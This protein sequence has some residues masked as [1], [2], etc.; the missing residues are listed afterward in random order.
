METIQSAWLHFQSSQIHSSDM[1]WLRHSILCSGDVCLEVARCFSLITIYHITNSSK[2]EEL[3]RTWETGHSLLMAASHCHKRGGRI[4]ALG[5]SGVQVLKHAD[6]FQHESQRSWLSFEVRCFN[7]LHPCY[8]TTRSKSKASW[9][10]RLPN[11]SLMAMLLTM[12][13]TGQPP[14]AQ[15]AK[16]HV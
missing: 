11:S 16:V 10:S 8:Q 1:P 12:Q 5:T 7:K 13:R 14:W 9:M 6:C 2:M 15:G 3:S 4:A